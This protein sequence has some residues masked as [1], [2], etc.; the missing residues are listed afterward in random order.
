MGE[1][2]K[3]TRYGGWRRSGRNLSPGVVDCPF[4]R[5]TFYHSLLDCGKA[6]FTTKDGENRTEKRFVENNEK[7][8]VVDNIFAEGT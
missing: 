5:E 4:S 2:S 6:A 7:A 8:G 3:S 1:Y